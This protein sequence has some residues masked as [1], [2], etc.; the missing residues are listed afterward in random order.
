MSP[1][2]TT[3]ILFAFVTALAVGKPWIE[4]LVRSKSLQSFRE[5][6]PKSHIE[7]K[8]NTPTMGGWIFLFPLFVA[9][10]FLYFYTARNEIMILLVA[11][12]FAA[13]MGALDDGLK[14]WQSSYKGIDSKMKLLLQF[15]ASSL[16]AFV[17]ARNAGLEFLSIEFLI[18]ALWAFLVIA[19]SSNALNLTDGLDGLATSISIVSLISFGFFL[20][21]YTGAGLDSATY[22]A[23]S[24][25]LAAALL[26]F[27]VYN[28]KPAQV[29]M[30]DT[31]SLALGMFF[32]TMAYLA[33]AEWYLF[34]FL[35]VPIIEALSVIIQVASA[36]LSRKFLKRDI[37]PFKMAPLHHHFEL[38][39]VSENMVV[40]SFS[41]VQ[42]LIVG[43]YLVNYFSQ[44]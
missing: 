25:T 10:L 3:L 1:H 30:G 23:L 39:G 2:L 22:L 36:K 20:Y 31:G 29:F 18:A 13:V 6:G 28:R 11:T 40:V 24:L 33:K 38:C 32:G 8:K 37:R 44:H 42:L 7:T 5:L 21:D 19:G 4:F 15:I 12:F 26:A 27:L 41:L 35:L 9:M 16:I 17:A 34:V 14:I 43:V